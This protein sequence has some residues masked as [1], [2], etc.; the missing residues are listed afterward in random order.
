MKNLN[1]ESGIYWIQ[2]NSDKDPIEVFCDMEMEG[3]MWTLVYSYVFTDYA[4]FNNASNALFPR[5]DWPASD[6]DVTISTT[7]PFF[8][9]GAVEYSLWEYIGKNFLIVS[10]INDWIYCQPESGS[11]VTPN[12]GSVYC[13]NIR[14]VT[15][16]CSGFAPS[17]ISWTPC[18]PRLFGENTM[19]FFDGSSTS[20]WP[21]HNPCNDS[22]FNNHEQ[23][24]ENPSGNIYLRS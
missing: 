2:P 9:L 21:V 24:V 11:L 5:P 23:N 19:Y 6:A 22:W 10:N 14:N 1:A 17:Q 15:S 13:E 20:C 7:S 8:G 3:G 18:G 12:N 16:N 4:N